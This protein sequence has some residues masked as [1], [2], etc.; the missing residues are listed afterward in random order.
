MDYLR[1]GQD[2]F[3]SVARGDLAALD[4]WRHLVQQGQVEFD[5]R[6]RREYLMS[7]KF[8]RFDEALVRLLELLELPGLGKVLSGALWVVRT[9]YRLMRSLFTKALRRPEGGHMPE[10]PVLEGALTGWLDLLRKESARRADMHP[11]WAHIDKGFATGLGDFARQRFEQGVRGFQLSL[12]GEIERTARAIYE[13]LEKNPVAL[14]TLRGTKF[15]L[16]V[17]SIAGTIVACGLNWVDLILVPLAA[18]VTHQLVELFGKGYVDAQR[19]NARARQ[20][21]LVTQYVS[22]PL[23][24]WL[25]QWPSTG[26]SAYERLHL[27]LRRIPLTVDQLNAVVT[28]KLVGS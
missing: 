11:V 18:S 19:E 25:A 4:A 17:G 27:A 10:R 9:P 12:G 5:T 13:E 2:S 22:G 15:A 16:E 26:G 20:M 21:A 6:Y 1:T 24:E 3:L 8:H 23:G 14:N 7:E 28:A